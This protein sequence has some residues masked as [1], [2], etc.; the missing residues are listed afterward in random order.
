MKIVVQKAMQM[1]R[2]VAQ[3]KNYLSIQEKQMKKVA[4][5]DTE[6]VVKAPSTGITK[7][8]NLVYPA[9]RFIDYNSLVM[10]MVEAEKEGADA[11]VMACWF[12][13]A[14][15]T[16]KQIIEVPVVGIAE[17]SMHLASVMGAKFA[18]ITAEPAYVA[19][20]NDMIYR[21]RMTDRAIGVRP[22]RAM[23][24]LTDLFDCVLTGKYGPFRKDFEEM[25]KGCIADGAEVIITGCSALATAVTAIGVTEI[26]GVPILN[27]V[28]AGVKWAEMLVD[29]K[30]VGMP[31]ICRIGVNL[32][33]PPEEAQALLKAVC[34]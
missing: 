4:R 2:E 10:S 22:V 5:R 33:P 16:A 15:E 3:W 23:T 32:A 28:V 17:V 13:S 21:Y 26:K 29:L 20:M 1:P 9:L 8:E 11:I 31:T 25:V 34:K 19:S 7:S 18:A 6:I 24:G 27:P 30:S 12:D 14:V